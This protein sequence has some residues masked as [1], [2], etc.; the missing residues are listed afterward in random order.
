MTDQRVEMDIPPRSAYV[1]V[2]RLGLS[3]LAR[4]A[5][6]DEERVDDLKI[7]VSEACANAVLSHE[8]SDVDLPVTVAWIEETGRIAVEVTDRAVPVAETGEAA[9]RVEMSMAL[10][11][12]LV[13]ECDYTRYDGGMRARLVLIV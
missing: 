12:S 1:G 13:D 10:L 5:G 2:V 9:A 11:E 4:A 8:R 7:A 6:L 3:A